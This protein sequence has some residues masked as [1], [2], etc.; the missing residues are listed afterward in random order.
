MVAVAKS[1][2]ALLTPWAVD[3]KA[4]LSVGFPR[5]EY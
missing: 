5:Q 4:H 1:C 2:P 3:C